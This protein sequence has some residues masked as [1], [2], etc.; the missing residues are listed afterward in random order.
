[1]DNE[2]NGIPPIKNQN[3]KLFLDTKKNYYYHVDTGDAVSPVTHKNTF[4]CI[5]VT[6]NKYIYFIS[7]FGILI[8]ST[9]KKDKLNI[10]ISY[11]DI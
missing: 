6:N 3:Q 4:P 7:Y 9:L 5:S 2:G 1:M 8:K 11:G 10:I